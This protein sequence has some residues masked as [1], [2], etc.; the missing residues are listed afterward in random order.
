L[1][2]EDPVAALGEVADTIRRAHFAYQSAT[3]QRRQIAADIGEA[4]VGFVD[5]L[6]VAGFSE[7]QARG[8]DVGALRDGAYQKG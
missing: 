1:E 6:A 4:T 5:A 8:A 7:M 2:G 3:E